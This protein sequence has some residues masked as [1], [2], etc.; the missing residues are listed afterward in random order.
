[1][2]CPYCG[3]EIVSGKF[4]ESCGSQIS[5]EMLKE[6][7]QLN[8]AGCPKCGSTN[9]AF[10]R[11]NQGEIRG[12]NKK[13]IVHRTVGYC[14]DCGATWYPSDDSAPVKK[15]KTWLWVL[16][17]LFIFPVP[18]TI[19]MLRNK[20]L[21]PALRYGIIAVAWII[22]L[23]IG[24][25]GSSGEE[26]SSSET[27]KGIHEDQPDVTSDV[28][29]DVSE[30]EDIMESTSNVIETTTKETTTADPLGNLSTEQK[31]AIMAAQKYIAYAGFSKKDLIQQ[32]SSEYGDNYPED[33]AEYAVQYL[34]E[35]DLVDWKAEAIESAKSYLD[36]SGFSRI[37]LISQLTSEYG[38]QYTEEEAVSAVEYLEEKGLVDWKQEAVES[39]Q[40]YLN[41]SSFSRSELY[42]QLT[43]K[44]G[45]NFTAEEAEYALSQVYD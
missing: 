3:A 4:C 18:L 36:F 6:Q 19:L 8:K 38:S 11:E 10:S 20:K 16:G 17:W 14:K 28:V 2:K 21:K 31:N 29:P 9:I 41:F 26:P 35:N 44:Y 25:G 42:D 12:K 45:E 30:K 39:A 43:S 23:I 32:L 5:Y 27:E 40:S 1:M 13:T 37:G 33:V 34:E 22:Y 24:L 15:R 7:E